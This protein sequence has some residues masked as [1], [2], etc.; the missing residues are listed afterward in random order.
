MVAA[1]HDVV[2]LQHA[3]MAIYNAWCDRVP[4][5]LLGGSGP[6]D[7]SLQRPWIEWIHTALVQGNLV[8]DYVKWDNQPVSVQG[9]IESILRGWRLMKSEPAAR[10]TSPW[11]S[12]FRR[13]PHPTTSPFRATWSAGWARSRSRPTRPV[14][15]HWQTG[16]RPRNDR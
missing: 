14:W 6:Q 1:L 4:I 8:R 11:T 15:R 16:W 12:P 13:S 7:S 5:L 2:G 3:S 9:A 10:S